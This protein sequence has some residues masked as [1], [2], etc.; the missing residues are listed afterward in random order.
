MA[1]PAAHFDEAM[2]AL[3]VGDLAAASEPLRNALKTN[4]NDAIMRHNLAG[5]LIEAGDV[6]RGIALMTEA[7]ALDK[8]QKIS[9]QMLSRFVDIF[10]P[11]NLDTLNP[12][13]IL[14][15]LTTTGIH[16]QPLT[17]LAAAFLIQA[18]KPKAL[19]APFI[20]TGHEQ[21]WDQAAED[22]LG[23]EGHELR[24]SPLF[25]KILSEGINVDIGLEELLI[26]IRKHLTL[27][28]DSIDLSDPAIASFATALLAQAINNEH[29]WTAS[30]E[31]DDAIAS[32]E[33]DRQAL[34]DGDP[35][36]AKALLLKGLYEP[37]ETL[38]ILADENIDLSKVKPQQLA[39][40]CQDRLES[41]RRE[42]AAAQ[43]VPQ[44]ATHDDAVT[45]DVADQYENNPYPRWLDL[46]PPQT[47][48]MRRGL[49]SM[50]SAEELIFFDESFDVL[51][52]GCGTGK[53]AIQAA[54]G[55]GEN[56]QVF[57][58]DISRASL[59]YAASKAKD[60]DLSNLSFA[61]TDLQHLKDS[62]R[63]FQVI[64]CVGVLHH[65]HD[66]LAGWRTLTTLLCPGGLM[67]IGLYSRR[68]RK[69]IIAIR[70][71]YP[72]SADSTPEDIKR[73]RR[74][75]IDHHWHE[76]APPIRRTKDLFST[77]GSRDLVF[78]VQEHQFTIPEIAKSL[79]TLGLEFRGF[80]LP[81]VRKDQFRK[82]TGPNADLL[83]LAAWDRY[84]QANPN[85]FPDMYQF[86]CYKPAI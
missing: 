1:T 64:E 75:L 70:E 40:L 41:R 60:H 61:L 23:P 58:I 44:L 20:E 3:A 39:S 35:Q 46:S 82:F 22:F 65:M 43:S 30:L 63:R 77:S 86:W 50:F 10:A 81:E 8:H 56:A 42:W 66:P 55:Y 37:F 49:G 14:A 26:A 76:L 71:K 17:R 54:Y 68:A 5:A 67:K 19:L 15:A 33:L 84:E 7:L 62:E 59:G 74:H 53:Q 12:D 79:G 9:A 2:T 45:Q 31:E 18:Q 57:A 83:D 69:D 38:P 51:I 73:M 16:K 24:T 25:H 21:G 36:A 47:G 11:D 48:S 13:G 28:A 78:H 29:V 34:E 32:L 85:S 6:G 72:V 52:A 80:Y 4:P 27:R